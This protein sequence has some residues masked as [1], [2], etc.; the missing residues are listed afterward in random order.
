MLIPKLR[1]LTILSCRILRDPDHSWDNFGSKLKQNEK[2][3]PLEYQDHIRG[4]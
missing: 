2:L 4:A 3:G 1:D